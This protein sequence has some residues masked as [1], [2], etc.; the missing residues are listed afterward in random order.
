[1]L[2]SLD[3]DDLIVSKGFIFII[4]TRVG[5]SWTWNSSPIL[6]SC[7]TN[8][9]NSIHYSLIVSYSSVD[10]CFGESIS[11]YDF[12]GNMLAWLTFPGEVFNG[13]Q[14]FTIC[15][16]FSTI[17]AQ[18]CN[19]CFESHKGDDFFC[20]FSQSVGNVGSHSTA[21]INIEIERVISPFTIDII[22]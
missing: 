21:Y 19:A 17:V 8:S 20:F 3:I 11:L 6:T 18:Y 7:K 14:K 9:I 1:M 15:E 22:L 12:L 2:F 5:I 16:S 10:I 4:S 13:D